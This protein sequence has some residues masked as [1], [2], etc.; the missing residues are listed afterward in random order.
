V[1]L[2]WGEGGLRCEGEGVGGV[3]VVYGAAAFSETDACADAGFDV[4]V[5][6]L[7]CFDHAHSGCEIACHGSFVMVSALLIMDDFTSAS[8]MRQTHKL[9]S[10][11][12]HACSRS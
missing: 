7:D 12:C 9:A 1:V 4:E 8:L 11:L 2:E 3:E 5:R 6:F 10:T